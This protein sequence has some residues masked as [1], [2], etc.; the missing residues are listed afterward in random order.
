M[1]TYPARMAWLG[2][3]NVRD[4]MAKGETREEHTKLLSRVCVAVMRK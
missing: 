4:A 3:M 1:S 2:L